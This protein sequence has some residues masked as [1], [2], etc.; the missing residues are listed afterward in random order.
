MID[1]VEV[2]RGGIAAP[3]LEVKVPVLASIFQKIQ[4]AAAD[5]ADRRNFKFAQPD[6]RMEGADLQRVRTC[7]GLA[8]VIDVDRNRANARTVRDIM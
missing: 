8:G 4:Q 2:P 1:R 6:R 7:H 5:T 3:R